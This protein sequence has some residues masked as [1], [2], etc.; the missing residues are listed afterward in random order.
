M[1]KNGMFFNLMRATLSIALYGFLVFLSSCGGG[2]SKTSTTM[3][4]TTKKD[5]GIKPKTPTTQL[6]PLTGNFDVLYFSIADWTTLTTHPGKGKLVFHLYHGTDNTLRFSVWPGKNNHSGYDANDTL[7]MKVNTNVP[8]TLSA[9]GIE[10]F[11]G[12]QE[13]AQIQINNVNSAISSMG[14]GAGKANYVIFNPTYTT[15]SIKHLVYEV[16]PAGSLNLTM[17]NLHA[18]AVT[19]PSPP[20]PPAP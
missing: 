2:G 20:S 10:F 14:S 7:I 5:T 15:G 11:M 1:K 8:A 3:Q 18:A 12:D 13:L 6:V 9:N 19:N 17:S 4:D 16:S